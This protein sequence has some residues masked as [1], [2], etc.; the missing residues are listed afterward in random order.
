MPID[1]DIQIKQILSSTKT[2]AVVGASNKPERDSHRITDVLIRSGYTVFPVN[3]AYSETNGVKCYPD[4]KSIPAPID[5]VDVFRNPEAVDEIVDESIQ[6]KAK[7]LW[8]QLGVINDRAAKRA[9]EAGMKVVMD[10]CIAVDHRR[11]IR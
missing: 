4:L 5:L 2:I 11:L 3:P 9:E 8:L 1:D 6:V 7:V 10:H